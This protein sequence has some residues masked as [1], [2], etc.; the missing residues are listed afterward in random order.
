MEPSTASSSSTWRNIVQRCA[1]A[2]KIPTAIA[3]TAA[4]SRA[5]P[6]A[7]PTASILATPTDSIQPR[8]PSW[9]A[10]FFFFVLFLLLCRNV[11]LLDFHSHMSTSC[12][13]LHPKKP[14]QTHKSCETELPR[15]LS[16]CP[17]KTKS[18]VYHRRRFSQR[19]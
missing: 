3:I 7:T 9:K 18:V 5:K 15:F 16:M 4:S 8:R 10:C 17:S 2:S 1:C 12:F 19:F 6:S 13:R 14:K 11:L